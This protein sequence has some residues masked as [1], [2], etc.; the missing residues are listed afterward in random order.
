MM[1]TQGGCLVKGQRVIETDHKLE[2]DGPGEEDRKCCRF[3]SQR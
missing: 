3:G 1:V 2:G